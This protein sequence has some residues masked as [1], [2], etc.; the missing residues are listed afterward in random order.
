MPPKF[1][2]R[3]LDR[4]AVEGA[5]G[6]FSAR[7]PAASPAAQ[8]AAASS[9][10][11]RHPKQGQELGQELGQEEIGGW[12]EAN[13][14]VVPI[15]LIHE[16]GRPTWSLAD[17]QSAPRLA[18][19][20]E[21]EFEDC[22]AY[23]DFGRLLAQ[24]EAH[25]GSDVA[26]DTTKSAGKRKARDEDQDEEEK[27]ELEEG[28][29][30][31]S[32]ACL[33][34]V[35]PWDAAVERALKKLAER[36]SGLSFGGGA[37][38]RLYVAEVEGRD[39][40]S[41]MH[42]MLHLADGDGR[43]LLRVPLVDTDR[44][45]ASRL[46]HRF[47]NGSW[48]S[49]CDKERWKG[50]RSLISTSIDVCFPRRPVVQPPAT[51]AKLLTLQLN[52]SVH[53][54]EAALSPSA[55]VPSAG[56]AELLQRLMRFASPSDMRDEALRRRPMQESLVYSGLRASTLTDDVAALQP[57]GLE[58]SL[59][60]FQRRSVHFL[61]G[62]EG[63]YIAGADAD[64]D[65]Q[66]VLGSL[67]EQGKVM[68]HAGTQHVGLWWEKVDDGLY[69]NALLGTFRRHASETRA[70]NVRG[71][72]LAEEMGLGKTVEVLAL[73]L[74]NPDAGR[75]Q[76]PSYYDG[77]QDIEVAPT[78]TTLIVAPEVLRQQWLDETAVHAPELRIFSYLGYQEARRALH[79]NNGGTTWHDFAR[80]LD[81]IVV[82]FDTLRKELNVAKKERPRSR[83][84]ERKYERPRS[85]LVQLAFHRVVMDEVQ[86]VGHSM[87]AETV[88]LIAR[89]HSLAV[90]GTPVKQ[91]SDL[92]S[93]LRFL[94]AP[95]HFG[96][97][98]YWNRLMT[99]AMA[100]Q[101]RRMLEVL[102]TRHTKEQVRHEMSLP[103]QTRT[104]VPIDF[105]AIESTFYRDMYHRT[106]RSMGLDD[107]SSQSTAT[108]R[109]I[110]QRFA[111]AAAAS[112]GGGGG[113]SAGSDDSFSLARLRSDLLHLRQACTHP[114]IAAGRGGGERNTLAVSSQIRSMD[115]VLTVMHEGAKADEASTRLSLHRRM[116][117]RAVLT[118]QDKGHAGR[119]ELARA[120]L[121]EDVRPAL[122]R[123]VEEIKQDL[124]RARTIGPFYRFEPHEVDERGAS[125]EV[126]DDDGDGTT[127]DP[128]QLQQQQQKQ[129]D[130]L[131]QGLT[132]AEKDRENSLTERRA[133]RHRHVVI[134]QNRLRSVLEQLHRCNHF[135]GNICF[136]LGQL[137][138]EKE[139]QQ[140]KQQ[141]QQQQQQEK[142]KEQEQYGHEGQGKE[143]GQ[144]QKQEQEQEHK[145]KDEG[146]P[147]EVS[148]VAAMAVDDEEKEHKAV[149]D[150][151]NDE[152]VSAEVAELKRQEDYWYDRAEE[153]R[154]ELLKESRHVV[155]ASLRSF[156][157]GELDLAARHRPFV[158]QQFEAGGLTLEQS[159]SRLDELVDLLDRNAE[160]VLKWRHDIIERLRKPVS[161]D[162]SAENELDDQYQENLDAQAEAEAL[163]EMYRVLLS[164]RELIVTG[165]TTQGATSKPA[166]MVQ[167]EHSDRLA[168]RRHLRLAQDPN[169]VEVL[170]ELEQGL[171]EE[172]LEVQRTQLRHFEKLNEER[173]AVS[174]EAIGREEGHFETVLRQLRE[175]SN[176]VE[177]R[178]E[179]K[180]ARM[181]IDKIRELTAQQKSL[182]E[183]LR[184][185]ASLLSNV[186][187]TRSSYFKQIQ[188]LSDQVADLETRDLQKDTLAAAKEEQ[189]L[190]A[191]ADGISARL[192]YLAALEAETIGGAA[193]AA[194]TTGSTSAAAA[195]NEE[196][197]SATTKAG[198]GTEDND[199]AGP[200]R[201][202]VICTEPLVRAVLLGT[203]GH[204]TCEDC[205][206]SWT[207]KRRACPICKRPVKANEAHRVTYGNASTATAAPTDA[208]RSSAQIQ[209][210]IKA[211]L[212]AQRERYNVIS[213]EAREDVARQRLQTS[214]GSKLDLLTRHLL[215]LQTDQ[216][217]TKSLIFTAFSRGVS[218]VS[219]ALSL[220]GIKHVRLETGGKAGANAVDNFKNDS[221]VNVLILHSEAQSSGLN[222]VCATHV[223]LLE[224]LV[225]H[226]MELQAI[227]R[228]HRIGQT[229]ETNV[230]GYAVN[231]T[232]EERITEMG[233]RKQQRSLF[234]HANCRSTHLR[235]SASLAA[236]AK[237]ARSGERAS[238]AGSSTTA[239]TAA[240]QGEFVASLDDILESLFDEESDAR[241]TSV[242]GNGSSS[243]DIVNGDRI[244]SAED[245]R[246]KMRRE[247][248]QAIERRQ[249]MASIEQERGTR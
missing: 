111:A 120:R 116:I 27:D 43:L 118:L 152:P 83:R 193:K 55:P 3:R 161:R 234:T 101:L 68:T 95:G 149:D 232:V 175:T 104:L 217:G 85:L 242:N 147:E 143:Q 211:K 92:Q 76:E 131:R 13:A 141:Q 38:D 218:L 240:R 151:K 82:S 233:R 124:V 5:S 64:A 69:Y 224:P 23:I 199:E 166:L 126:V 54:H 25:G 223:F 80:Q 246:E 237:A 79:N 229:H 59:I 26:T 41:V 146:G 103:L 239:T 212:Q 222:L 44:I 134:V 192:R 37:C 57:P 65:G 138:K 247:R 10:T 58:P 245:E 122:E 105:T 227:G 102:G 24:E 8:H 231:S 208:T 163:L 188:D 125:E 127:E 48:L 47:T 182:G 129:R 220:N 1:K 249:A 42:E 228:V 204:W 119:H 180:L 238:A 173:K 236:E 139:E 165:V 196:A 209:D 88:S 81:V 28:L 18:H 117:D 7:A 206:R 86:L 11:L 133:H 70:D 46:P 123:R 140:Q 39:E 181:A 159:F 243:S 154:L 194:A 167:L 135:L 66:A 248:L 35:A 121:V 169:N 114:Q 200:G 221:S 20:P 99:P 36:S 22:S 94:K 61:L 168:R 49:A 144:A 128:T 197:A 34:H 87:A 190:R 73:I 72:I 189:S 191:K 4:A 89:N 67:D 226:A 2:A 157:R 170:E 6:G 17:D 74:L 93:L 91:L 216:P 195:A 53:L 31:L 29:P 213:D 137:Q 63:R 16:H 96:T 106:L 98:T 155:E 148:A 19:F 186:F 225:N 62:R 51:P 78:K 75:S 60:P 56:E 150:A 97:N 77:E 201:T 230:W 210:P 32:T 176:R 241:P 219:D 160:V 156:A 185:E 30:L 50:R 45:E 110:R 183:R 15:Q 109:Q 198:Q 71:G 136:Q 113:G 184:R 33:F 203:C 179:V 90:S 84:F 12:R 52:I 244:G 164:E 215:Q 202:C 205:F 115:E 162:V 187:N 171:T 100:P 153:V 9:S 40:A 142:E 132:Q 214:L 108:L 174:L 207:L 130:R 158:T 14:T 21:A 178:E 172:Q 107:S 177:R 235:D 145:V 112:D